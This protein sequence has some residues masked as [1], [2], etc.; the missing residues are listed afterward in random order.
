M[1]AVF[2]LVVGVS[3]MLW[4]AFTEWRE[5]QNAKARSRQKVRM[6]Q[7][8]LAVAPNAPGSYEALGDAMRDADYYAEAVACYEEA[9]DLAA[10][11]GG[12]GGG[13][14]VAGAGLETK[15][16]LARMEVQEKIAPSYG[17]TMRTRQQICRSCGY[18]NLP[19]AVYCSTC[20][21]PLPVNTMLDTLKN[22]SMR[23]SIAQ[24]TAQ[25]AAVLSIILL[26]VYIAS[27][28][29]LL[30]RVALAA[31]AIIV[32]PIRLLKKII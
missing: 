27:W 8:I 13:G 26:A 21:G 11:Q 16:K 12:P 18:L 6:R 7:Q 4:D 24:E 25:A 22:D 28:M 2:L 9:I 31:A 3:W 20:D 30:M 5:A 1:I 15:L 29:P 10:K 14:W 17:Q 32:I 23:R 19:E